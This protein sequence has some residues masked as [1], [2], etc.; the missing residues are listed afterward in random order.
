MSPLT[1]PLH[2]DVLS[3]AVLEEVLVGS[4]K[5]TGE[6]FHKTAPEHSRAHCQPISS[7]FK[8]MSFMI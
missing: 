4:P 3:E 5:V 6:L 2:S 8:A 7:S 1:L